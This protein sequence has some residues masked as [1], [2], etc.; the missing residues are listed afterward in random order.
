MNQTITASTHGRSIGQVKWFNNK[1]GYGFITLIDAAS[2]KAGL[3]IFVHHTA[4]QVQQAQYKYL[5]QGEY[6]EFELVA[7]DNNGHA[8][9]AI[10][11]SGV[12]SGK[13]MCETRSTQTRSTQTHSTQTRSTSSENHSRV[14]TPHSQQQVQAQQQTR[15]RSAYPEQSRYRTRVEADKPL[16]QETD[17]VEWLLVR[18]KKADT[19]TNSQ[20][21]QHQP[22][23]RSSSEPFHSA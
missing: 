6:V 23:A 9:Q 13:L 2:D 1:A 20:H 3:D 8:W 19:R 14:S 18:R 15:P 17:E 16:F 5:V 10:S 7:A 4:V 22:F 21:T 12:N 11:V